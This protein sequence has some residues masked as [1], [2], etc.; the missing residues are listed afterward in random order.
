MDSPYGAQEYQQQD[1]MGASPVRLVVMAYDLAIRSCEREDFQ[2]ATQAIS[3]LRDALNFEYQPSADL[4]ALYQ[5]CLD[6]LREG[7]YNLA[8]QTLRELRNAWSAVEKRLSPTPLDAE[9]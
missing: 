5:W 7:S 6:C 3:V 8:L 4:F 2:R 1:I 9:Q